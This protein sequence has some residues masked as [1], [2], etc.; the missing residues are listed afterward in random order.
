MFKE[1]HSDVICQCSNL[2][3]TLPQ[4]H[5]KMMYKIIFFNMSA[6][7]SQNYFAKWSSLGKSTL[8]N[9]PKVHSSFIIQYFLSTHH[10]VLAGKKW[11]C[12]KV[13]LNIELIAV[14]IF[15]YI[16]IFYPW[17]KHNLLFDINWSQFFSSTE[18]IHCWFS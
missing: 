2:W 14:L 11:I 5:H 3:Y 9:P 13:L 12:K 8:F 15:K 4:I 17:I 18:H 7:S 10:E 1:N 16:Y 6:K